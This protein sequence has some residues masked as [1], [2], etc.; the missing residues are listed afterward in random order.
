MAYSVD[1]VGYADPLNLFNKLNGQNGRKFKFFVT[2]DGCL[3]AVRLG[4]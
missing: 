2:F 4:P 3:T 1:L